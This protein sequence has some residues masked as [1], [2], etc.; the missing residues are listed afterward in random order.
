LQLA[1]KALQCNALRYTG[2]SVP[3]NKTATLNLRIDPG[4]KAALHV[5]ANSDHRSLANMVEV[6]IKR[7]CE[8]E[9]IPIPEQAER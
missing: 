8:A 2:F 4:L 9:G 6:L 5:A 1:K 3:K 7:H